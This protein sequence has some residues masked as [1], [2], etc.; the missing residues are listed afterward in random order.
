M[1]KAV[2]DISMIFLLHSVESPEIPIF[3]SE[4]VWILIPTS[5]IPT[6]VC[7]KLIVGI[8]FDG[9]LVG[10]TSQG[11]TSHNHPGNSKTGMNI[12]VNHIILLTHAYYRRGIFI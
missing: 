6:A 7:R 1:S 2:S 10:Y 11:I 8:T 3:I 9:K 12:T 4:K 5:N